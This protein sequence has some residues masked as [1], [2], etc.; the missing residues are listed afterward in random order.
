MRPRSIIKA[1]HRP[2]AYAIV[3]LRRLPSTSS[4]SSSSSL[5]T[6]TTSS[7][8]IVIDVGVDIFVDAPVVVVD[9]IVAVVAVIHL[10]AVLRSLRPMWR[11][12]WCRRVPSAIVLTCRAMAYHGLSP[13]QPGVSI[14]L[15]G[16]R[17]R[18]CKVMAPTSTHTH[19]VVG[20]IP[21]GPL[22]S[23]NPSQKPVF[24]RALSP[25]VTGLPVGG[26]TSAKHKATTPAQ[27]ATAPVPKHALR[28]VSQDAYFHRT[29]KLP[30]DTGVTDEDLNAADDARQAHTSQASTDTGCELSVACADIGVSNHELNVASAILCSAVVFGEELDEVDRELELDYLLNDGAREEDS[31]R[32]RCG[33]NSRDESPATSLACAQR[34]LRAMALGRP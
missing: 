24:K 22:P 33:E 21:P 15:A 13:G 16:A 1:A 11:V 23:S 29:H 2:N 30:A 3:R 5:S 28:Q 7:S 31:R 4:S 17:P 34:R 18:A 32:S 14:N 26:R 6:S 10:I 19:R 8:S 12:C 9:H 20:S 25:R 27:K